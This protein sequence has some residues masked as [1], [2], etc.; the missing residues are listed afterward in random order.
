MET[1]PTTAVKFRE[2]KRTATDLA[3][4]VITSLVIIFTAFGLTDN[5][6]SI[7]RFVS[8]GF[9]GIIWIWPRS[10]NEVRGRQR[11][12]AEASRVYLVP[13]AMLIFML[14]ARMVVW[15]DVRD[16]IEKHGEIIAFIFS[17]SLI[18]HGMGRSHLFEYYA[19]KI[20]K[21]SD[22]QTN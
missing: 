8:V 14:L 1:G 10:Q 13:L 20:A 15:S 2:P 4:S 18:S 5:N 11:S 6:H 21:K 9:L 7:W 3:A 16:V 19:W 12:I 17:F 22:G